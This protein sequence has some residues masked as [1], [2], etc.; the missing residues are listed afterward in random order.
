VTDPAET[1][2]EAT[3]LSILQGRFEAL[4]QGAS[5]VEPRHLL[6]GLLKTMHP[7]QLARVG[8][9]SA[10]CTALIIQLGSTPA[11]APLSPDDIE[12][13]EGCFHTI[14]RAVEDAE[15]SVVEPA[16]LLAV[17]RARRDDG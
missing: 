14:A 4:H 11:P 16:D 1:L 8:L 17:L 15:G 2:S 12:Y 13:A 5:Q 7:D 9:D 3:R 10:T 6:L